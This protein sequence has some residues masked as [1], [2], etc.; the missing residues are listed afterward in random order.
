MACAPHPLQAPR[1]RLGALHL[2]DEVDGAHVDAQLQARRGDETRDL[3]RLQELLDLHPLLAGQGSMMRARDLGPGELVQP[4]REPLREAPV[5][6][7]DDRGAMRP[8]ELEQRRV[9]R[10]PDGTGR[11]LV[12][13]CHLARRPA[14]PAAR[15]RRSRRARGDPRPAP[16]PPG[17]APCSCRHPRA[18]SAVRPATK[19]PISSSGRCVADSPIRW[20]GRSTIRSSRS[21]ESVRCAPR[22]VPATACTSSRITVSTRPASTGPAT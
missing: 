20:N 22:F 6:D 3:A 14:T 2:H 11:G 13:G 4:D 15:A 19:R 10:G 9:D 12:P 18:R 8:D 5:V 7:E 1:D 16:R 17:R 21:S